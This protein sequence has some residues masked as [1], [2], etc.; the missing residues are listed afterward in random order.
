MKKLNFGCGNIIKE[1]YINV[2]IQKGK[3]IDKNFNFNKYPYPFKDDTFNEVL[4]DNVLEHLKNPQKILRELWRICKNS[5][6]IEIIVPYYNSYYAWGDPTHINFF[7]ELSIKQTLGDVN[8]LH[9]LQKEKF[10]IIKLES[11]PQRF[12]RFI[13]KSMLNIL[14]RIF[15][16]I[17]VEIRVKARVIK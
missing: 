13:P 1:G 4:I 10:E 5:A 9:N 16:N 12:L 11:V 3:G 7:N 2:D 8:Y 14:K 15:G 17:I 6:E